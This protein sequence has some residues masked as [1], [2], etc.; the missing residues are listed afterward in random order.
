MKR[1][2]EHLILLTGLITTIITGFKGIFN[3]YKYFV[4]NEKTIKRHTREALDLV[5]IAKP[6]DNVDDKRLRDKTK[7][8]HSDRELEKGGNALEGAS[9]TLDENIKAS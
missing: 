1:M 9:D 4:D 3:A 5:G 6:V 2:W 7:V 8:E